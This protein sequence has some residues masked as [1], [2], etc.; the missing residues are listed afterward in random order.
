MMC[1][2]VGSRKSNGSLW[3]GPERNVNIENGKEHPAMLLIIRDRIFY[4]TM[5]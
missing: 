4:L 3:H 1:G 5:L 2:L